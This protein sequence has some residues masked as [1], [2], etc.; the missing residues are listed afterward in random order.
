MSWWLTCLCI[1]P[2]PADHRLCSADAGDFPGSNTL[3]PAFATPEHTRAVP[4]IWMHVLRECSPTM[5]TICPLPSFVRCR[6]R[7][8]RTNDTQAAKEEKCRQCST[9]PGLCELS[10]FATATCHVHPFNTYTESDV[11]YSLCCSKHYLV[12]FTAIYSVYYAHWSFQQLYP[13]RLLIR[14][15]FVKIV[16]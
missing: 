14:P 10:G 11:K 8:G 3:T 5:S 4:R 6:L 16:Y 13:N 7:G 12:D 2:V 1:E 15:Q 9:D